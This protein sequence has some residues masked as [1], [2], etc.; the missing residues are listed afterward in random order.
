MGLVDLGGPLS[1]TTCLLDA[2]Q[3]HTPRTAAEGYGEV[4][5]KVMA[6]AMERVPRIEVWGVKLPI[7]QTV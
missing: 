4:T 3:G 6:Q 2:I 5:V 7:P 1:D